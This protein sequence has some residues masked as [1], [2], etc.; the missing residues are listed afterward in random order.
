[1]SRTQPRRGSPNSTPQANRDAAIGL[2]VMA[3]SHA[4]DGFP[5]FARYGNKLLVTWDPEDSLT[6]GVLHGALVAALGLASRKHVAA[7]AGEIKALSGIEQRL[8]K[9]LERFEKIDGAA[10]KIRDQSEKI[11]DEVR[12]VRKVLERVVKDAKSPLTALKRAPLV[13]SNVGEACGFRG[14]RLVRGAFF[15]SAPCDARGGREFARTASSR[16]G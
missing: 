9:E 4:P 3:K 15:E 2:F 5:G 6:D 14:R 13:K 10:G 1:M 8:I 11:S 12:K 16:A 7:D